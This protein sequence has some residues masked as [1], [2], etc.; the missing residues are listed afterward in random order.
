LLD[1][2]IV[3]LK[4]LLDLIGGVLLVF[5]TPGSRVTSSAGR[6][7]IDWRMSVGRFGVMGNSAILRGDGSIGGWAVSIGRSRSVSR[8]VSRGIRSRCIRHNGD[9]WVMGCAGSD[10]RQESRKDLKKTFSELR[11]HGV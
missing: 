8:G 3:V 2:I 7:T 11:R 5:K 9:N 1:S 4:S 6:W 10:Y